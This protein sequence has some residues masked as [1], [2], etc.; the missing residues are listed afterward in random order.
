M[1]RKMLSLILTCTLIGT[2]IQTPHSD[3][4]DLP[5]AI[6]LNGVP[7]TLSDVKYGSHERNSLDVW[8]A[9]SDVPTPI[10]IFFTVA[11]LP[12]VI[13][14]ECINRKGYPNF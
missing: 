3:S 13:S 8:L 12:E 2:L 11:V 4:E 14:L 5:P 10:V 6:N 9:D 7:A 1:K